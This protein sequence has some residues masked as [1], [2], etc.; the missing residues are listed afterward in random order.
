M[1]RKPPTPKPSKS[2]VSRTGRSADAMAGAAAAKKSKPRGTADSIARRSGQQFGGADTS[3][4]PSANK[5]TRA[6]RDGK[7][8]ANYRTTESSTKKINNGKRISENKKMLGMAEEGDSSGT[9]WSPYGQ[10][11]K[12]SDAIVKPTIKKKAAAKKLSPR[13]R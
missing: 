9:W 10:R 12:S 4:I 8:Y 5:G 13:Q 3:G 6:G 1:P 11:I 7:V 2:T